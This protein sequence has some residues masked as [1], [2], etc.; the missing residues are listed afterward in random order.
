MITDDLKSESY[1]S[2][3]F[4]C[5]EIRSCDQ[6]QDKSFELRRKYNEFQFKC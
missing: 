2:W 1:K 5:R 3:Y 6:S 4:R